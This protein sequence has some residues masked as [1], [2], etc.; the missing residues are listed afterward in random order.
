MSKRTQA[1]PLYSA[2]DG[3]IEGCT[4]DQQTA[5][6]RWGSPQQPID[7]VIVREVKN[8][9]KGN[10]AL[11]EIFRRDWA[12]DAGAVDQIFQVDLDPGAI[13]AWHSHQ[14]TTDRLFVTR[15]RLTIV[16]YDARRRSPTFGRLNQFRY[17]VR[18]PAL[19]VVPP[20][21]WHGIQNTSNEP[22]SIVNIV[23]R[24]YQYEDPDHWRL[25][26]D[27][28]KIPYSFATS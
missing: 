19:I 7:G 16:L 15:G 5:T 17:G 12:I 26:P 2:E 20:G 21:V 13:S 6:P 25:P 23:D 28:D 22:A 10:G 3:Y 9:I 18:R 8:I 4:K 1:L 24:A 14:R 11:T 27:T